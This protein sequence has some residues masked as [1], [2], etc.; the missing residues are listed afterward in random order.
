MDFWRRLSV[1]WL[2]HSTASIVFHFRK[3]KS[4]LKNLENESFAFNYFY[5]SY[6]NVFLF[7]GI[8][9]CL[10][11]TMTS[12]SVIMAVMVINLYNRGMKTRRAPKWLRKLILE[13]ASSPLKMKHDIEHLAKVITLVSHFYF[14]QISHSIKLDAYVKTHKCW[15][16]KFPKRQFVCYM[17]NLGKWGNQKGER[18]ADCLNRRNFNPIYLNPALLYLF[19]TMW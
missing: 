9:L 15:N 13:I 11:M 3:R 18:K 1:I 10:V 12:V 6:A 2:D 4:A 19:M 7:L 8:Y 5:S 17:M 14:Y 16:K